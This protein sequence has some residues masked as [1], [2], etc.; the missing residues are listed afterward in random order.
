MGSK[1]AFG[2]LLGVGII[3]QTTLTLPAAA[4][5][6]TQFQILNYTFPQQSAIV[7]DLHPGLGTNISFEGTDQKIETIFINNKSFFVLSTNGCLDKTCP[8][9]SAPT[10]VNIAAIDRANIPGSNAINQEA[11]KQGLLTIVT[12]DGR[13]RHT[14]IF[15]IRAVNKTSNRSQISLI[16]FSPQ[17]AVPVVVTTPPSE[18]KIDK[19]Q[20]VNYLFKGLKIALKNREISQ[21]QLANIKKFIMALHLGEAKFSDAPKYGLDLTIVARLVSLGSSTPNE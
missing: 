11:G 8:P 6:K 9:N 17:P 21:E 12:T 10:I 4:T 14:Q 1:I 15:A 19:Q 2:F 7:I 13:N 18:P 5:T 3:T 20:T 16:Q